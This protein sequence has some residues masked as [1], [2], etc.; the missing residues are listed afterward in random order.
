MGQKALDRDGKKKWNKQIQKA[1]QQ[2]FDLFYYDH[3]LLGGGNAEYIDFELPAH[4]QRIPNIAGIV[5]GVA[6]W[7][8]SAIGAVSS[9]G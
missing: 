8:R 9:A 1:I 2:L 4:A 3:L 5:G 7:D 6:L